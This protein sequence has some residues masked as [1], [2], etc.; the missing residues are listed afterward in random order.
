MNDRT[1]QLRRHK[2]GVWF[3]RWAGKD[4]YFSRNRGEAQPLYL[5]SL[6]EWADWR[7]ARTAS[8]MPPL[9]HGSMPVV[10]V[11]ELFLR[12]KELERGR[13]AREYYRKHIKRFLHAY[14]PLRSDVVKAQH[15]QGI[16]E[17]MLRQGL[18]PKTANHDV[19]AIKTMLRWAMRFEYMPQVN[20]DGVSKVPLPPPKPKGIPLAAVLDLIDAADA[21]MAPWLALNYLCLMRPSEVIRVACKQGEWIE[22]GVYEIDSKVGMRTGMRRQ[23][24]FSS[25]A[26]E[27]FDGITPRWSRLD[28][29][30]QAVRDLGR[31]G[32]GRLRH[33]AATHL[34]RAGASR[35]DVSILLGVCPSNDLNPHQRVLSCSKTYLLDTESTR[36]MPS[37]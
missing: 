15:I 33:S 4:H 20:L 22:E 19:G 13:A 27:W 37:E 11:A 18:M 21:T 35:A 25:E 14:G 24:V 1:P 29:Y 28:S 26:M 5:A 36:R 3:C 31:G 17:D 6:K 16:K 12:A 7:A 30:S 34:H 9:A 10:E 2:T 8:R 23:V 32:P